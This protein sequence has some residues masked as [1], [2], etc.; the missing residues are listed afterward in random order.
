MINRI[1]TLFAVTTLALFIM[2]CGSG[3]AEEATNNDQVVEEN[4]VEEHVHAVSP[5]EG[6]I[7]IAELVDNRD[8]YVGQTVQITGNCTKINTG[9]LGYNWIHLKDGSKDEFDLVITSDALV[10]VGNVVT[11]TGVVAVDKDFG[12]GYT[13]E[14]IIQEGSVVQ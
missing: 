6:S 5:A 11:M 7:S 10:T 12:A 1:R 8:K 4:I 14:L 9:I 13:Y 3:P 2:A